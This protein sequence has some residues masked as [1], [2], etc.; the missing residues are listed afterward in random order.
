MGYIRREEG[1]RTFFSM[2]MKEAIDEWTA[3]GYT[4][5]ECSG[6]IILGVDFFGEVGATVLFDF[7]D[8]YLES[9]PLARISGVWRI[10]IQFIVNH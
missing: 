5:F 7:G 4:P 10:V 2:T 6:G 9:L 8:K 3:P 1:D